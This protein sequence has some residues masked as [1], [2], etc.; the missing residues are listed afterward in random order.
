MSWR[1]SASVGGP[2][3]QTPGEL[4]REGGRT[5]PVGRCVCHHT[6]SRVDGRETRHAIAISEVWLVNLWGV[7][8]LVVLVFF[9]YSMFGHRVR[10]RE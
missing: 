2:D 9:C 3:K 4:P 8:D 5:E 6:L 7:G 10:G 1:R